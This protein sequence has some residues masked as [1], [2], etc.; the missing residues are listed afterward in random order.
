M[1]PSRHQ[2]IA[3]AVASVS[4]WQFHKVA[5]VAASRFC[6][7]VA[8]FLVG[9]EASYVTGQLIVVDGG[10]TIQESKVALEGHY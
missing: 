2:M 4:G 3:S 6:Y 9:E 8:V 5:R 7:H 10:N 1:I